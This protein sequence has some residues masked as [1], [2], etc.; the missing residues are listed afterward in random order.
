MMCNICHREYSS[1]SFGGP[2]V[3][4]ACD[5]G[6]HPDTVSVRELTAE[7]ADT[8]QLL[9]QCVL[10]AQFQFGRCRELDAELATRCQE[11]N[12]AWAAEVKVLRASHERYLVVF[13]ELV[14]TRAR[15]Q[16]L[17][18]ELAHKDA[19]YEQCI[20]MPRPSAVET[21]DDGDGYCSRHRRL[22]PCIFCNPPD[23]L[24]TK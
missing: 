21:N 10:D 7:L 19:Y 11:I 9:D 1:P 8:K 17:E 16:A 24:E 15:A 5:C 20:L 23:H 14:S 13:P 2:G 3:C 12:D 4:P 6:I 18:S 22:V